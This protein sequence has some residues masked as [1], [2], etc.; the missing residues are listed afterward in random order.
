MHSGTPAQNMEG[1]RFAVT[2][3]VKQ[4]GPLLPNLLNCITEEISW[5][6]GWENTEIK[7]NRKW[8]SNL[9]FATDVAL[10]AQATETLKW[11]WI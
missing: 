11:H 10:F 7:I 6:M 2:N 5:E 4:G 3:G 9:R 1:P 8:L